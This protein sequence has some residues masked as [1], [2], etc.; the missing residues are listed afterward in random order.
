MQPDLVQLLQLAVRAAPSADNSQPWSLRVDGEQI[1]IEYEADRLRGALFSRSHHATL[2]ALGCVIENLHQL[3]DAAGMTLLPCGAVSMEAG[4]DDL[5]YRIVSE[6]PE[7]CPPATLKNLPLFQRHTNRLP[8]KT[9][10]VAGSFQSDSGDGVESKVGVQRI[11]SKADIAQVAALIEQASQ[12]RFQT[13]EIHEWFSHSLRFSAAEVAR[14]DGLDVDTLGLPPG[15]RTLLKTI[16][17]SWRNMSIFNRLGG[18]RFLAKTEA[19]SMTKAGTIFG[20][21]GP[22]GLSGDIDA[23]R[24][25]QRLWVDLNAAGYA[26]QPYYVITDQLQRLVEG[27]VP[28]SLLPAVHKLDAAVGKFFALDPN[29]I[30]HM[31]LRV[32]EPK[33]TPKRARRLS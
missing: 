1:V 10:R 21:V 5:R 7:N 13:R 12:V 3:A 15:G 11:D 26:V 27:S 9:N 29:Q 23:G 18:Y 31:L 25:M 33:K 6:P 16:T 20:I 4:T 32:G 28:S 30:V 24:H 14:G 8:F 19:A 17:A 22:S 2:L